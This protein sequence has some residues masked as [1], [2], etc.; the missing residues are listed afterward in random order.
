MPAPQ[1][2]G[3]ERL[4]TPTGPLYTTETAPWNNFVPKELVPDQWLA[5]LYTEVLGCAPG[6]TSYAS[7]DGYIRAHGC[8]LETLRTVSL[9]FLT[10]KQ[11]LLHRHYNYA[12]RL[13]ILWRVAR[14]SEPDAARYQQLLQALNAGTTSWDHVVRS[15]FEPAG[16]G[17]ELPR[18]CSGQ[19]F[20]WNA[21]APVIDIP[22]SHT[23]AFG[24]G[25]SSQLQALLN[26]AKR[27]D[28]V[29]LER[30]AVVRVSGEVT[31]PPGVTLETVGAP[32]PDD[33]AAMARLVRTLTYGHP[34]VGLSSGA[35]LA[36]VWV[37]GQ[38]SNQNVGMDHDSIDVE[39]LGGSG[40]T[41]RDDRIDNTAGW[42]N[43][44]VDET[45]PDRLP[46]QNVSVEH[47]LIDGYSTK[48]HWYET[49][50][51]VDGR[52]DVG[53]G[54]G[55]LKN[56]QSGQNSVSSTFGF[57]DGI[58]N[59]CQDSHIA[60]NQIVDATDVSIVLFG[61]AQPTNG[62]NV[63]DQQSVAEDNTIVNAGNSGW[64]AVT[65]DPLYPSNLYANFAGATISRNLIWTGP[66][67]FLL[68]IAGIGTKPWFGDNNAYGYGRVSFLDNTSGSVRVN[69]QMAIGVSRMSGAVVQGN[70]LLADLAYA[71]QCPQG[72][73][74]GVDQSSGSS[75]QSPY[76]NVD[77]GSY[78]T[79]SAS[80]GCLI[81]H[82]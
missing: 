74:I 60:H 18:L 38:R 15:F 41:V 55:Q 68:L 59:Q 45:G 43:L 54:A 65:V 33:Y 76:T 37:D 8:S 22:T 31:I 24:D 81:Y 10:S 7:Y 44:L 1:C 53:T 50:G 28:T 51:V 58:S 52:V 9:A 16:F 13:L 36:N 39:V 19:L 69:T 77:F 6:Q 3:A 17:P 66:N 63:S 67:A 25:T 30:G 56:L 61:A 26:R 48:F 72:A 2:S 47:N 4:A 40:T 35:T 32:S 49:T 20:G 5:K 29:W 75:V 57:A 27:G 21:Q 14:E 42:S 73:Y 78:P 70:T 34:V 82:L 23:R 79:P 12:E 62:A 11:F 46:C 71:D 64:S 80:Q